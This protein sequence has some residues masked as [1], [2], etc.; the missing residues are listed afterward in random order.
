M[1]KSPAFQF[2]PKDFL[3]DPNVI[4]MSE[5]SLGLYVKLL[6]H[7]WISCAIPDDTK[8]LAKL[9][10]VD[11]RTMRRCWPQISPC[12]VVDPE[13][14]GFLR[15]PRLDKERVKQEEHAANRAEAGRLGG[16][17]KASNAKFLLEQNPSKPLANPSSASATATASTNKKTTSSRKRG[18][19]KPEQKQPSWVAV[20]GGVWAQHMGVPSYPEIGAQLKPVV[21][22]FGL[23][24]VLPL[25]DAFLLDAGIDGEYKSPA[26]F[27]K[28]FK[29]L[30]TRLKPT[31]LQ[32]KGEHRG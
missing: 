13:K 14:P 26:F 6:C 31:T 24:A 19:V 30:R 29:Q 20:M 5:T 27:A 16:L 10:A 4:E 7:S 23:D 2:Y 17:A 1:N 18:D 32:F 9:C 8:R 21:D 28:K 11:S 12:F 22:E 25:W 3:V 15:H